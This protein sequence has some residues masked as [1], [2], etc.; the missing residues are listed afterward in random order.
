MI[1]FVAVST[2]VLF[3]V[4][5]TEVVIPVSKFALDRYAILEK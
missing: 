3:E 1:V 5:K 4:L 2:E